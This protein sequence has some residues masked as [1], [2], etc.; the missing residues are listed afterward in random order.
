M[1]FSVPTTT[2][3]FGQTAYVNP[4]LVQTS[5]A[6]SITTGTTITLTF[7]KGTTLGNCV[8]VKITAHQSSAPPTVSGIT[9]GGSSTNVVKA[10][11]NTLT[12][13]AEI[14]EIWDIPAGQTSIVVTFT[15]GTGTGQAN[16]AYA[17]EWNGLVNTSN[18]VD[19]SNSANNSSSTS[20]TSLSITPTQPNELV[21][22]IAGTP[23]SVTMTG[24]G[25]PWTNQAQVTVST[26]LSMLG[27]YIAGSPESAETFAGTLSSAEVSASAIASF[28]TQ[29]AP[30]A[31]ATQIVAAG[32]GPTLIFNAEPTTVYLGDHNTIQWNDGSD[33]IALAGRAAFSVN[34]KQS[35]Y[36]CVQPGTIG[37][38]IT[39]Q[40]GL[41]NYLP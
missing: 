35:L 33:V 29:Q 10:S 22:G 20:F 26:L 21:S 28:K 25:A 13:D 37:S 11:A 32:D 38:I 34:G 14:W 9:L 2:L 8:I 12:V 1:G 40:G 23:A 31:V 41:A 36:A 18:P 4:I 30:S 24:P 39:I 19:Q 7:A 16:A 3:V 15:A 6:V 27:G 5:P 17:E